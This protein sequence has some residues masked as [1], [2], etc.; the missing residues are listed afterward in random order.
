MDKLE[1]Y[2]DDD[3]QSGLLTCAETAPP[4]SLELTQLLFRIFVLCPDPDSKSH[5]VLVIGCYGD[6]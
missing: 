6:M 4:K 3:T 2:Y 1:T 5:I